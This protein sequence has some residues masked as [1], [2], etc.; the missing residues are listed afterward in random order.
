MKF[1][2][3][4]IETSGLDS[5]K[6]QVLSI[7]AIVEDTQLKL[8]FEEIPKFKAI[9]LQRQ[10]TGSPRAI[11]MNKEIIYYMGQYLEGNGDMKQ[12]IE[13][14]SQYEFFEE[15]DVAKQL[16]RFLFINGHQYGL[17]D[18]SQMCEK[19]K[20]VTYPF[21]NVA[22][23][24]FGTFDKLFLNKLPWFQKLIHVRQRILDP[25]IL[26]VDWIN[27]ESLPSLSECKERTKIKGEVTHDA[28]DD[29]WD[30]IQILRKS[31]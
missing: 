4:D 11:D 23:K 24:N 25:A 20:G 14:E 29:A 22:G 17:T 15:E 8:P 21:I 10:I 7:G 3:I 31:Y 13:I 6:N 26:H 1:V 27:D 18:V 12:R 5:E 28:L 16:F 9:V 19:I 2:S 30:V